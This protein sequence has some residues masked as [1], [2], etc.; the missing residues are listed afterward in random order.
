MIGGLKKLGFGFLELGST[1]YQKNLAES[2]DENN[3]IDF[4]VN[5]P[6][7]THTH[8]HRWNLHRRGADPLGSRILP[9]PSASAM[10]HRTSAG[11]N[12]QL[13]ALVATKSL[14]L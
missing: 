12:T 6:S 14:A 1:N 11:I 2:V 8:R 7:R 10:P 9:Q 3:K 4:K 13:V 5:P